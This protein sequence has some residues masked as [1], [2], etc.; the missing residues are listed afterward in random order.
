M[1]KFIYLFSATRALDLIAD[2]G[3]IAKTGLEASLEETQHNAGAILDCVNR[4][5]YHHPDQDRTVVLPK[6]KIVASM[7]VELANIFNVELQIDGTLE[8]S[9]HYES[10]PAVRHNK[11]NHFLQFLYSSNITIGGSGLIDGL[12]YDW[13]VRE[14]AIANPNGRP[15]LIDF[16]GTDKIHIYGLELRNSPSFYI[17]LG[18]VD[19]VH[20]HDLVIETVTI[21]QRASMLRGEKH[22]MGLMDGATKFEKSVFDLAVVAANAYLSGIPEAVKEGLRNFVGAA[23]LFYWPVFPLNTD[24]IDIGGSNVLVENIQI[25]NYD[26]AVVSKPSNGGN[27][28]VMGGCTQNFTVHNISTVFGVG[29]SIGSVPPHLNHSCVRDVSFEKVQQEYPLKAIYI[30]TNPC[31][32]KYSPE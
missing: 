29:M 12:G 23:P 10:W 7:S 3:A 8:A 18:D 26:D 1:L 27:K 15:K 9:V 5:N 11:A 25:R 24:G 31:N 19:D 20:I 6:G 2:C 32:D 30:K 22:A 21:K 28:V 13:W 14:F 16:E 4:V 17:H